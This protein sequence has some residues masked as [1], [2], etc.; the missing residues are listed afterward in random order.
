MLEKEVGGLAGADGEVLLHFLA[1][2][3]AEGGI[4]LDDVVPVLFPECRRG[5]R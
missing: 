4:S 2:L 1:F 3:A 5:F